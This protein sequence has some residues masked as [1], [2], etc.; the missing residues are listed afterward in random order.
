MPKLPI[1]L[2]VVQFIK[3]SHKVPDTSQST[4]RSSRSQ[5][6]S[7][8]RDRRHMTEFDQSILTMTPAATKQKAPPKVA[9]KTKRPLE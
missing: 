5:T 1:Y 8:L 4:R 2:F 3:D 9:P 7:P 6:C